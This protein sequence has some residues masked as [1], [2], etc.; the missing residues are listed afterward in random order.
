MAAPEALRR[1]QPRQA[2]PAETADEPG[3]VVRQQLITRDADAR[4]EQVEGCRYTA[5]HGD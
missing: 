4:K 3:F 5:A 2:R 1:R